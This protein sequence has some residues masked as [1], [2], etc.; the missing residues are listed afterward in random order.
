MRSPAR[1]AARKEAVLARSTKDAWLQGPSDLTEAEVEDVPVPG[2]SVRVRGLSARYSAEVQSQFKL[3]TVGNAQVAKIDQS[4]MELLQF[5]HGCIEPE[6]TIDEA[7]KIQER[8][9]ASF[10]KVIAKID[11]LSGIDKEAI[12][13]AEQRFQ[14]GGTESPGSAGNGVAAG[15]SRPDVPARAGA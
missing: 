7:Q 13:K 10:R 5:V 3:E 11:E 9:G 4:T 2:Q 12:E 1:W 14:D 6:F 8:M 15:G